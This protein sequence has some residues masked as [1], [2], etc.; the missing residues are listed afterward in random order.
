MTRNT[1]S[2]QDINTLLK[3]LLL[4]MQAKNLI[5]PQDKATSSQK[6]GKNKWD[7]RPSDNKTS[8][9]AWPIKKATKIGGS[10]PSAPRQRKQQQAYH[11]TKNTNKKKTKEKEKQEKN[12]KA[13]DNEWKTNNWTQCASTDKMQA[14]SSQPNEDN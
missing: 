1:L 3:C 2:E 10:N 5:N 12:N 14:E 4:A 8:V 9:G 7:A 6:T 11:K 13:W